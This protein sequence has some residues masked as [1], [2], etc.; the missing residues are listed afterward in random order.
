MEQP[1]PDVSKLS[2]VTLAV[3]AVVIGGFQYKAMSPRAFAALTTT[4]ALIGQSGFYD[5][6]PVSFWN[7]AE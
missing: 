4:I 1:M 7:F 3:L 5:G 2:G 6:A